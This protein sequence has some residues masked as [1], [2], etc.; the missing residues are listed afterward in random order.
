M[1][2]FDPEGVGGRFWRGLTEGRI[3]IPWCNGCNSPFFYPRVLCPRCWSS[4]LSWRLAAGTGVVFAATEARVPFQGLRP[5]HLPLTVG[6]VDL[7]EGVRLPGHLVSDG[8][9]L[10][11]GDRVEAVWSPDATAPLV[12]RSARPTSR[13]NHDDEQ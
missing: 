4:D 5:E 10:S 1:A 12:F 2:P 13:E 3:E 11:P 7:D 9:P 8:A 6:L